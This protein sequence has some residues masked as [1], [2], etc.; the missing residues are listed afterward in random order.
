[1]TYLP[2]VCLT[3]PSDDDGLHKNEELLRNLLDGNL[4]NKLRRNNIQ[5]AHSA[6]AKI[7]RAVVHLMF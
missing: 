7:R 5:I 1:M 2:L 6:K 3:Y 4:A